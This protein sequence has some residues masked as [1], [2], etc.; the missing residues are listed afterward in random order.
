MTSAGPRAYEI[1][2]EG[3]LDDHWS[4]Q[5]G[6]LSIVRCDDGTSVLTGEV[7]DQAGLHGVI[8]GLRDIGA[9][10]LGV[11]CVASDSGD[12]GIGASRN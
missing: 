9:V 5:L 7:P 6:G 1:R 12:P 4:D 11:R 2:V 3:H 10:L 8:C